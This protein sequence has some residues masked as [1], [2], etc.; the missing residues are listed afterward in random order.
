MPTSLSKKGYP[1]NQLS[2]DTIGACL[3]V[4]SQLGV[5]C[6]EVD[7]QRALELALAMGL[8]RLVH[9]PQGQEPA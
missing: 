2:Y 9:T 4:Q 3:D 5:H 1:F 6:M 8:R 7:Y